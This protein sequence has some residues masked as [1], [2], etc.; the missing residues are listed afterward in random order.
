MHHIGPGIYHESAGSHVWKCRIQIPSTEI[1]RYIS[2]KCTTGSDIY[3]KCCAQLLPS[4]GGNKTMNAQV[5]TIRLPTWVQT[6]GTYGSWVRVCEHRYQ[7]C[8][9]VQPKIPSF[10]YDTTCNRRGRTLFEEK[11]KHFIL[12]KRMM[13]FTCPSENPLCH[14]EQI[15]L[16][17]RQDNPN[18]KYF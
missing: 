11:R 9:C 2:F 14:F 12:A 16:L 17:N 4:A 6:I 8:F 3:R 13:D 10:A 18:W 5:Q 15:C 1:F 7:L